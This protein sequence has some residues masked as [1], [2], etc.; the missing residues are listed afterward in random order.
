MVQALR[1]VL[2]LP[3]TLASKYTCAHTHTYRRLSCLNLLFSLC[4]A[5][6]LAANGRRADYQAG[7]L[8]QSGDDECSQLILTL[9]C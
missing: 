1:R 5:L 8:S 3:N 7:C 2:N 9:Y 4:S 6:L